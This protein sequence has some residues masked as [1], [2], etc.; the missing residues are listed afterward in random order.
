MSPSGK[1]V[2]QLMF[3]LNV[4]FQNSWSFIKWWLYILWHP[5]SN[6]SHLLLILMQELGC[7][8]LV[9]VKLMKSQRYGTRSN[10]KLTGGG[11]QVQE[12]ENTIRV[13]MTKRCKLDT[14]K[15]LKLHFK[16]LQNISLTQKNKNKIIMHQS[17]K[18]TDAIWLLQLVISSSLIYALHDQN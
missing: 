1:L 11:I 2:L 13:F 15:N 9:Y 14:L 10:M 18:L 3:Y 16:M 17:V 4:L 6:H 7:F 8:E 12:I 5:R